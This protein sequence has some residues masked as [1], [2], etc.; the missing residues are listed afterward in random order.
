MIA[1][2]F[3]PIRF[4]NKDNIKSIN[5]ELY[6]WSIANRNI[7]YIGRSMEIEKF[8]SAMV[9]FVLPSYR[10]GFGSVVIEAEAMEVPVIVT[11]IPGPT[12]AMVNNKSGIVIEKKNDKSLYN[13]IEFMINNKEIAKDM[14]TFGREF[15]EE[16][17]N[18]KVV[19]QLILEDRD[20]LIKKYAKG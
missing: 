1:F 20:R 10:E 11:D 3:L 8:F 6:E 19:H 12:D 4:G 14:G 5:E 2:T 13:A 18:S 16:N 9:V 15:I 7:L 17:F